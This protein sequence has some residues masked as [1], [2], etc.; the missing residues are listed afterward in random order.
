M[1]LACFCTHQ[2]S[3]F[4][5]S[6]HFSIDNF[7]RT[8]RVMCELDTNIYD[9]E[10]TRTKGV[11]VYN[12]WRCE[13]NVQS[14]FANDRIAA[15]HP[16][17]LA[18]SPYFPMNRGS[19]YRKKR[20]DSINC[21]RDKFC[22]LSSCF[23]QSFCLFSLQE[24]NKNYTIFAAKTFSYFTTIAMQVYTAATLREAV[25]GLLFGALFVRNPPNAPTD[26]TARNCPELRN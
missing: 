25:Y 5:A 21:G 26:P 15:A 13:T 12:M 18:Q 16:P 1:F 14:N 11:V 17:T 3:I 6:C 7:S 10:T 8:K 2:Y 4:K 19:I 22:S 24:T 23:T 20:P 9:T